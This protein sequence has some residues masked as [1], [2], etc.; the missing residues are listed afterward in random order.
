MMNENKVVFALTYLR[1]S[2]Y[3]WF[4]PTLINF[5]ENALDDQKKNT[6]MT[7]AN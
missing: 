7:F 5:L 4:E 3:D 1:D 6:I 2:A